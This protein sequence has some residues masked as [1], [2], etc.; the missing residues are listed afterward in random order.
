M[1]KLYRLDP[2]YLEKQKRNIILLYGIA[3]LVSC[4]LI[5]YTQHARKVESTPWLTVGLMIILLIFFGY[6]SYKQRIELWEAY[7]LELKEDGLTQSQPGYPSSFLPFADITRLEESKEGLWISTRQGNRVFIIPK[8]LKAEDYEELVGIVRQ[9]SEAPAEQEPASNEP[10]A[11]AED[12]IEE[13][14]TLAQDP[15]KDAADVDE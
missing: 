3:G 12:P 15:L 9:K 2:K 11:E 6:R 13:L 1:E 14:P 5:I 8:L 4:G 7:S 10:E